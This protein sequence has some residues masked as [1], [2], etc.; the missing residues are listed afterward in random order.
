MRQC[1][2]FSEVESG[3]RAG[4][5][6]GFDQMVRVLALSTDH[7]QRPDLSLAHILVISYDSKI[8]VAILSQVDH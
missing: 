1:V 3:S 5:E 8:S 6:I 7:G 2:R 4:G